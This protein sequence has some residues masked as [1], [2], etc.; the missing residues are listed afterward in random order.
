G[1]GPGGPEAPAGRLCV[2]MRYKLAPARWAVSG[3]GLLPTLIGAAAGGLL[4]LAAREA[5]VATPAA[6]RWLRAALE[7]LRRVGSEGYAPSVLERRRLAA[8]ATAAAALGGWLLAG[9]AL[10]RPLLAAGAPP[11]RP[12]PP[13][14][15]P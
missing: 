12:A 8:L 5:L 6:A 3:G 2:A 11:P 9:L 14:P 7:P 10:A 15:P 1:G 4:A 13:P